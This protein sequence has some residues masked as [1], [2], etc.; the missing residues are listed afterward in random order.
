[1][2]FLENLALGWN[3]AFNLANLSYCFIGVFIGTLI[4]V[5]PGIGPAGAVACAL[6]PA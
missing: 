3:T 5:L 6:I 4:G 2:G 1:M